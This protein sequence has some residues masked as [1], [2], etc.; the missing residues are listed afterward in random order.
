MKW[1]QSHW[2]DQLEGRYHVL[3]SNPPYITTT[4]VG[5]LPTT[6]RQ[7][8]PKL[9]LDGGVHGID[10]YKVL[11]EQGREYLEEEGHLVLEIGSGQAPHILPLFASWTHVKSL[12]DHEGHLRCL[13]FRK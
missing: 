12:E 7:F 11:A 6:I 1:V 13:V 4:D 2:F 10:P 3:V 8:E 9:A 5:E